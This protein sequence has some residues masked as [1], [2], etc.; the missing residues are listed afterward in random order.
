M[1]VN[2]GMTMACKV[3]LLNGVHQPGDTYML[4]LYGNIA[5]LNSFTEAYVKEGEAKGK[6]Y[7]AGGKPLSGFHVETEGSRAYMC[8]D[9]DVRWANAT[10]RARH[11]LVYNKSKGNRAMTILDLGE[12][13]ASTNGNWDI[14]LP[15]M[16][17]WIG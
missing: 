3:D 14:T 9:R 15:E 4:A 1:A 11:A 7:I 17:I 2:Y 10:L 16:L 6:G 8:W 5:T 13:A 12:E